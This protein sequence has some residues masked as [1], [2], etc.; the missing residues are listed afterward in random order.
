MTDDELQVAYQ[1]AIAL[2]AAARAGER[3]SFNDVIVEANAEGHLGLVAYALTGLANTFAEHLSL[4][5]GAPV[6]V[7][8]EQ[9]ALAIADA[10]DL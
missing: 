6:D 5:T 10:P 1:R 7:L 3:E 4:A 9:A 8:I 2:L